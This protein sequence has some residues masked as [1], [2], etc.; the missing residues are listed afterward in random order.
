MKPSNDIGWALAQAKQHKKVTRTG[1]NNKNVFIYYVNA[2]SYPVSGN[3]GS[4]LEGVYKD[5][6]VPYQAY[7]AMKTHNDDVVPFVC[8]MD[9][10]LATDWVEVE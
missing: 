5:D 6:L 10:L 4:P 3:P 9:S 7:I 1:W 8:G 2:N